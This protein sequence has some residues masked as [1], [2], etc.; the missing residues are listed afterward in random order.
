M[1]LNFVYLLFFFYLFVFL[2]QHIS[3]DLLLQ[4]I[5]IALWVL[6]PQQMSVLTLNVIFVFQLVFSLDCIL[7]LYVYLL[8][9][10]RTKNSIQKKSQKEK[11]Y[12]KEKAVVV[13]NVRYMKMLL[14]LPKSRLQ[15]WNYLEQRKVGAFKTKQKANKLILNTQKSNIVVHAL[16]TRLATD[17]GFNTDSA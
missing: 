13:K 9:R 11:Y 4:K 8:F 7:I 16:I 15:I 2:T 14:K 17:P 5:C 10:L 12:E 3:N 1:Q 6:Q